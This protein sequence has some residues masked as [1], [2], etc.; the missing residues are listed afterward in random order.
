MM[1]VELELVLRAVPENA[2]PNPKPKPE[3]RTKLDLDAGVKTKYLKLG[4]N[5]FPIAGMAAKKEDRTS[6]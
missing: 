4:E 3:A 5:R 6:I 2:P 1:L